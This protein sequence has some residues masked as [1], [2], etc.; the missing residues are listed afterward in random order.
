[1]RGLKA[2][3]LADDRGF[4]LA[5]DVLPELQARTGDMPLVVEA[6][7][8]AFVEKLERHELCGGVLYHVKSAP[9]VDAANRCMEKVRGYRT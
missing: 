5:F 4:P 8:D 1:M 9:D 2:M 6:D 3:F 7:F